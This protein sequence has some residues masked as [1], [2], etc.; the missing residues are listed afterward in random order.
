MT[1][2][3]WESQHKKLAQK[4]LS[5]KLAQVIAGFKALSGVPG[6]LTVQEIQLIIVAA[7]ATVP[8]DAQHTKEGDP[9]G[10]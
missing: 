6:C 10:I 5:R 2:A 8:E 3:D 7:A 1:Q 9:D 4:Q